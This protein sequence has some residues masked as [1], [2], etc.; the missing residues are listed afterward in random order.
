MALTLDQVNELYGEDT[1]EL[2]E[3]WDRFPFTL[4]HP[5]IPFL[6]L[7]QVYRAINSKDPSFFVNN[8]VNNFFPDKE[9][10]EAFEGKRNAINRGIRTLNDLCE[11]HIPK[12][13]D[14]FHI[15]EIPHPFNPL[16]F[17]SEAREKWE[18]A[19][20][21]REQTG[22]PI[23]MIRELE[24]LGPSATVPRRLKQVQKWVDSK[25]EIEERKNPN[26]KSILE[27][28][29]SA[30]SWGL[31]HFVLIID[32]DPS[33]FHSVSDRSRVHNW[34]DER[35]DFKRSSKPTEYQDN[36]GHRLYKWTNNSGV[37]VYGTLQDSFRNRAKIHDE[38]GNIRYDS[39]LMKMFAKKGFLDKINDNYAVDFVVEDDESVERFLDY[40]RRKVKSGTGLE[41]F[42]HLKKTNPPFQCYKFII[43]APIRIKPTPEEIAPEG[44]TVI[45][46]L[47]TYIRLPVE[48]QI[49]SLQNYMREDHQE[50]KRQQFMQVFSLWY[51]REIYEPLLRESK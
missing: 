6:K 46:P 12:N 22:P 20:N 50:Y 28:Y 25:K 35:L 3:T 34:L 43:R 48:V 37:P 44:S 18:E 31:G 42:K 39:L 8:I 2:R 10:E 16:T 19:M 17:F 7:K 29:N 45:M 32:E 27:A 30:R 11:T 24:A 36:E 51:P 26:S 40:F 9:A 15:D 4:F 41:K 13:S 23:E 21:W 49:K 33:V 1:P 38:R 47:E 5:G 14:Y